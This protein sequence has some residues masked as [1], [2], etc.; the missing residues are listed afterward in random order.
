M[1]ES[2]RSAADIW[3]ALRGKRGPELLQGLVDE[4]MTLH[5]LCGEL[6]R[7]VQHLQ[8]QQD[9]SRH[10]FILED[11]ANPVLRLPTGLDI[12]AAQLLD[13]RDGFHGLEYGDDGVPF[14][15]T[16][17]QRHFSFRVNVDRKTPLLVEL[18]VAML[19]DEARQR[20]L[21]LLVD[22]NIFAVPLER[23]G[24]RHVGRALLPP[25]ERQAMTVLTF[26]VPTTLR[27]GSDAADQR[28]LGLAFRRLAIH[29]AGSEAFAAAAA[30]A[31]REALCAPDPDGVLPDGHEPDAA[32][33]FSCG[34]ADIPDG[35]PGFYGL[36]RDPDGVPFRWSKKQFS[37][38]L[39]ID[40]R[41]PVELELRA[42]SVIDER[43]QSPL[44]LEVDD[45]EYP[46]A[47]DR[48]GDH[49]VGRMVIPPR[50]V[51]GPTS[52][53]FTAPMLLRPAGS[54]RRELGI[55]FGELRLRPSDTAT[56][57]GAGG[58][59]PAG[60]EDDAADATAASEAGPEPASR[61]G[62]LSKARSAA[63]R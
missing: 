6:G 26:V 41:T 42:V 7:L 22:G 20:D 38:S 14:R 46:L 51:S 5:Q 47:I 43:R 52:L 53:T 37:F 45:A 16:G 8:I 3:Q 31:T 27:V 48:A 60:T 55:A 50:A 62:R 56:P 23:V 49:F 61:S 4:L 2:V 36:E 15:W 63:S 19:M 40:R 18:D 9:L 17:P 39:S 54:D 35:D 24:S 32:H 1:P 33:S 34:A 13:P 28:E 58:V 21:Q 57:P 11:V 25:A 44:R 10:L 59:A 30:D 12:Y 29:P